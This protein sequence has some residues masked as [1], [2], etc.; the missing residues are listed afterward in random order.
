VLKPVAENTDS[1]Q[2]FEQKQ[3]IDQTNIVA[4]PGID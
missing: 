4:K 1:F 2:T 3:N